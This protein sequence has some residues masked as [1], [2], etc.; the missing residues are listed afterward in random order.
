VTPNTLTTK[1]LI[2]GKLL[3]PGKIVILFFI[4]F[5]LQIK[6]V[7][8][9]MNIS[10]Q[11]RDIHVFDDKGDGVESELF[12]IDDVGI[13][14]SLGLTD[15][16]GYKQVY[17]LCKSEDQIGAIPKSG[18]YFQ[19]MINCT[20]NKTIKL[21]LGKK[22]FYNLIFND[23][24]E[25]N[26]QIIAMNPERIEIVLEDSTQSITLNFKEL[27]KI[28]EARN[29]ISP[30]KIAGRT[31]AG[32]GVGAGIGAV[33][34]GIG[35]IPGAILGSIFGGTTSSA[36]IEYGNDILPKYYTPESSLRQGLNY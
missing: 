18:D 28:L 17:L 21:E 23:E 10:N 26:A 7:L 16:H 32:A 8:G 22:E 13:R 35:A 11:I 34:F 9:Q 30:G 14:S 2:K 31:A 4:L 29:Y 36:S 3:M 20:K 12:K 5:L 19:R 33:F 6:P 27:D 15:K 24:K 1:H 25:I